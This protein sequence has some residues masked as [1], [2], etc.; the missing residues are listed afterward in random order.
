M[1]LFVLIVLVSV[2]VGAQ[3]P[4]R[5]ARIPDDSTEH[6]SFELTVIDPNRFAKQGRNDLTP[7]VEFYE[8]Y[9]ILFAVDA[10]DDGPICVE[11]EPVGVISTTFADYA[12]DPQ[13]RCLT[14]GAL[15]Q[16]IWETP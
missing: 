14:L 1:K 16:L 11:R 3:S 4:G 13:M 10:R 12:T 2:V 8:G 15:R 5:V 6:I 7:D 9:G